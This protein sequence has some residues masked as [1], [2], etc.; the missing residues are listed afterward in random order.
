MNDKLKTILA[1]FI[2]WAITTIGVL[3]VVN[4]LYSDLSHIGVFVWVLGALI[5]FHPTFTYW[6]NVSKRFLNL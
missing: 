1:Y 3:S 6:L 5:V 4:Y 2:T